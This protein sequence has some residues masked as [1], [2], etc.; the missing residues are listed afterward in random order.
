MKKKL[1]IAGNGAVTDK[2]L[3]RLLRDDRFDLCGFMP[4]NVNKNYSDYYC[5]VKEN[6]VSI[7]DYY[8]L[9]KI[10]YDAIFALEYRKLIPAEIVKKHFFI[11]CHA[12]IL[13]KYRGF[14]A[15]AW[16]IMNGENHIGY[17]IHRMN[18]K[19]D[20]G[21]LYYVKK[22]PISYDQTYADV[23]DKMIEDIINNTPDILFNIM[24][25]SW[26]GVS[27]EIES[28]II[29]GHKFSPKLGIITNF[30]VEAAYI[31]NL[32]RCMARPLGSGIKI[33]Y[34]DKFYDVNKVILGKNRNV[35]N[36]V[37]IP[38]R[39]VNIDS[40]GLWVKTLDNIIIL[41]DIFNQDG[42]SFDFEHKFK[43]GNSLTE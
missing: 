30:E 8:E 9:D 34:R 1:I 31:Y 21:L 36:Y 39:I 28:G 26:G 6:T 27:Q 41:G 5:S 14:H 40:E 20:D 15:N 43:I 35:C 38:G 10:S 29:F 12:G 25:G 32:Y 11:N 16:A 4:D 13:P 23:H 19:M 18:E 24:N 33:K 7:C 42:E 37:G 2:L 17:S 22:I 3:Q